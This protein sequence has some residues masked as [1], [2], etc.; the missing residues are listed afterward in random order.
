MS[1]YITQ[2]KTKDQFLY[3]YGEPM[4]SNVSV[5]QLGN[6]VNNLELFIKDLVAMSDI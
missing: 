5:Q 4:R 6:I 1:K 3:E 2:I